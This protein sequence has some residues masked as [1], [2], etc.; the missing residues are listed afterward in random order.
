M[1]G[2]DCDAVFDRG[3]ISVTPL[4]LDLTLHALVE[5]LRDWDLPGLVR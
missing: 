5:E 1:P 3:L 4:H 2:S